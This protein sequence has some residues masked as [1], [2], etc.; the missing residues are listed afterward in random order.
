MLSFLSKQ[1]GKISAI[2]A[3][4]GNPPY[5]LT[6]E[7]TSDTPVYHLFIDLSSQLA[8]RITLITPARYLFEAGKTPKEWNSKILNDE[9]FKVVNYWADSTEVFPSVDI[10]GGVAVMLRDAKQN[11]G[12]IG[13]FT[14]YP[15]L[16]MIKNRVLSIS[17][18]ES[19]QNSYYSP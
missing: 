8:Q 12:K 3:I 6:S 16:T 4:I 14:A 17:I 10:K 7:N 9:H 2:D 18:A 11:F 1:Y 19:F 5:Q 13:T 15:E